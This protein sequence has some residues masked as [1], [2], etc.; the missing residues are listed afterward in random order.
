[1]LWALVIFIMLYADLN[2]F[3]KILFLLIFSS[4]RRTS[5]RMYS[6]VKVQDL[7]LIHL[8]L[9]QEA[10]CQSIVAKSQMTDPTAMTWILLRVVTLRTQA[11]VAKV[12]SLLLWG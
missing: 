1:M 7:M 4:L 8:S 6:Q 12:T 11:R 5:V 3:T 9:T 2:V 10:G